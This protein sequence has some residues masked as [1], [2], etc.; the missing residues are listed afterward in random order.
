[1]LGDVVQLFLRTSAMME[2]R[3]EQVGELSSVFIN[4]LYHALKDL[5][6]ENLSRDGSVY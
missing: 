1:M 3:L 6:Q 5:P 4:V 2:N